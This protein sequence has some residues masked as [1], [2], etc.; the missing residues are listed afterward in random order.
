LKLLVIRHAIAMEQEDFAPAGLPDSE[1][2]LTDKGRLRMVKN[3]GGLLRLDVIP[4]VIATSPYVRAVETTRIVSDALQVQRIETLEALTPERHPS[5]LVRWLEVNRKA[6]TVAIVG[7][8]PH[9]SSTITWLMSGIDD[10]L[11]V[12]KKGGAC[13]LEIDGKVGPGSAVM[14][15]LLTP[16]LL[17]GGGAAGKE[18]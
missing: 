16:R 15:W 12:M 3:A 6:E 9:L 14:H 10:S 13:L 18:E 7:H 8:E 1:R 2:P 11:V 5:E 4:E 17:R